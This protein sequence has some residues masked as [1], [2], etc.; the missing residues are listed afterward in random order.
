LTDAALSGKLEIGQPIAVLPANRT[1][2]D[3]EELEVLGIKLQFLTK[4]TFDD[5]NL[6]VGLPSRGL[7][8][9]NFFRPGTPTFRTATPSYRRIGIGDW[10]PRV[11]R[12]MLSVR[13]KRTRNRSISNV[14]RT[15]RI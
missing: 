9:N 10:H 2:E 15:G 11:P 1:V 5:C 14:H 6:T 7:V 13:D 4:F 12:S 3:G 8:M